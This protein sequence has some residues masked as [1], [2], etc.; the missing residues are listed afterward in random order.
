MVSE[1]WE[2]QEVKA[3]S[4]MAWEVFFGSLLWWGGISPCPSPWGH[5]GKAGSVSAQNEERLLCPLGHLV[6]C[7][8][9]EKVPS[10]SPIHHHGKEL[11]ILN[12][13]RGV[14]LGCGISEPTGPLPTTG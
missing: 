13:H 3:G 4:S 2:G 10:Y 8:G 1:G 11:S 14:V 6:G 12:A 9:A 7:A 5:F